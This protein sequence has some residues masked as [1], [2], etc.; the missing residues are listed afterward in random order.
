METRTVALEDVG[1]PWRI[2]VMER[3]RDTLKLARMLESQ[4]APGE[5]VGI[6]FRGDVVAWHKMTVRGM[7]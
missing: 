6:V 1:R 7:Q 5:F 2:D 4:M 3:V